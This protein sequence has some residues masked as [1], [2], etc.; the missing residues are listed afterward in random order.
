M[1]KK[2]LRIIFPK[3]GR[4]KE[5]FSDL[6]NA[7][8]FLN[9]K[10]HDRHDFGHVMDLID[11][12]EGFEFLEQKPCDALENLEAG[13]ADAA[14]IG[15]DKL[16]EYRLKTENKSFDIALEFNFSACSLKIASKDSANIKK[17]KD[18]E[19]LTA[20]TSYPNLLKDFL[21]KENVDIEKIK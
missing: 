20:V 18:L 11:N 5:E 12:F 10:K 2:P 8:G 16:E 14:I 21:E 9:K 6:L 3:K 7:S 19:G 17:P 1:T 13:I 15:K 4:L